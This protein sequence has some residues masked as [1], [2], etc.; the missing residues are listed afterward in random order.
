MI[1]DARNHERELYLNL[2]GNCAGSLAADKCNS[3]APMLAITPYIHLVPITYGTQNNI[4]EHGSLIS[5]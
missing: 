4:K 1:D 3:T 5:I 2:T